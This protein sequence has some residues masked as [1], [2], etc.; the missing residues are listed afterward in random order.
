MKAT[1]EI[2]DYSEPSK[3][4]IRIHSHWCFGGM[5]ELEVNGLRYT[6]SGEELK[7]AIDRVM[8]CNMY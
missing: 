3:P 5:I 1:V 2:K 8:N 7:S 6:V 4:C